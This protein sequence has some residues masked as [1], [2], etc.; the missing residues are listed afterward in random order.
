V[1]SDDDVVKHG[2]DV[3]NNLDDDVSDDNDF[4]DISFVDV[5]V[6]DENVVYEDESFNDDD[7]CRNTWLHDSGDSGVVNN[8]GDGDGVAS[9]DAVVSATLTSVV[10][11]DDVAPAAPTFR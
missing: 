10:C 9:D 3:V 6:D 11:D 8:G 5:G 2:D 7:G 1:D 4:V